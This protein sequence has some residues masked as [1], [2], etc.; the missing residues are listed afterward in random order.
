MKPRPPAPK[1]MNGWENRSSDKTS[2][3]GKYKIGKYQIS[4]PSLGKHEVPP[5]H[6]WLGWE[7]QISP[8][9]TLG[10]LGG[11]RAPIFVSSRSCLW[12]CT[13][14]LRWSVSGRPVITSLRITSDAWSTNRH[15]LECWYRFGQPVKTWFRPG[16]ITSHAC[17]TNKAMLIQVRQTNKKGCLQTWQFKTQKNLINRQNP[18]TCSF[19]WTLSIQYAHT[20]F[21]SIMKSTWKSKHFSG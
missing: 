3:V 13:P 17:S 6:Q 12:S 14:C 9:L 10:G 18:N 2:K 1:A 15:M 16:R 7:I 11:D 20:V 4:S 21:I 19:F 8:A 5:H